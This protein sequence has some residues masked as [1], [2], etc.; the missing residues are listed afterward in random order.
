M[1]K[2]LTGWIEIGLMQEPDKGSEFFYFD[3]LHMQFFSILSSDYL[4]FDSGFER[5]NVPSEYTEPAT[6]ELLDKLKRIASNDSTIVAIPRLGQTV[7]DFEASVNKFLSTNSIA[8]ESATLWV[9]ES[10]A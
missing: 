1:S 5:T 4:L 2:Q 6:L 10:L 8:L 9:P 7:V 3:K